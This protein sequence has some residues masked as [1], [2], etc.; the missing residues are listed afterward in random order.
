M[1]YLV[2]F[3]FKLIMVCLCFPIWII[4]WDWNAN[5]NG[6]YDIDNGLR[7]MLKIE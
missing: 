7:L 2:F 1:K 3:I 4:T 5:S 6:Y